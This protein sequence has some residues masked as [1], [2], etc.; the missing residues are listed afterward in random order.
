MENERKEII[1]KLGKDVASKVN[2]K[3]AVD[4]SGLTTDQLKAYIGIMEWINTPFKVSDFKRA[5]IGSAGVGKT[6][7]LK[8]ILKNCKLAYST[9]GISAP[10]H[11]AVRVIKTSLD[12]IKGVKI[13][14]LQS[15][16]GL[17]LN[18]DVEKFDIN[19]PP[20]DPKGNVKVSNYMLYI[21]DE[22]SMINSGL[23]KFMEKIFIK[24]HCKVIYVGDDH[25]LAPVGQLDIPAFKGTKSFILKQI[26]R[27]EQD[28]PLRYILEILRDDI[29]NKS[30]NFLNYIL[31]NPVAFDKDNTKG[32]Q[33][34]NNNDFIV[35]LNETF[36]N[37]ELTKD[38]DF[39][40]VVSYTNIAVGCWNNIIRNSII[41]DANKCILTKNDLITSYVTIVDEFN[42]TIIRN[43]EDYIIHD[44]VNYSHPN[45]K[46]KGFMVKFQAVF[47]GGITTPLFVIDH[48]DAFTVKRY[49]QL[50]NNLIETARNAGKGVRASAWKKYY[51]FK[52][53]CLLLK[54]IVKSDG[55]M[56]YPKDLDYGFALTAHKSQGSTYNTVFV[57]INDIVYDKNGNVYPNAEEINRRLYVAVSRA[58]TKVYFRYGT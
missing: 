4:I 1:D 31:K 5:I 38:V 30:Y 50:S 14:T 33:V 43:S 34:L 13:N 55:T 8:A 17:R 29:K 19:N 3:D 16:F 47:G 40:R 32:Y 23:L 48:T 49:C 2:L 41:K 56:L 28:N 51:E 27:Q 9:I 37:E 35:K 45:Y 46:L 39:V 25:Q 36:N 15:D 6:F 26:V 11:K 52:E 24:E 7:L 53:S 57:D 21:I 10:T 12:G 20:F 18:L 42:D 58:K 44:I 22:S 54:N